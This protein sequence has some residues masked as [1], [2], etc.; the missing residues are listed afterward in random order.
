[1]FLQL[2]PASPQLYKMEALPNE[3][4]CEIIQGLEELDIHE[5]DVRYAKKF[6][7]VCDQH[8]KAIEQNGNKIEMRNGEVLTYYRCLQTEW[9]FQITI[10][11]NL[12]GDILNM[13]RI[14]L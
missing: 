4:W 6:K 8:F 13:N 12:C 9:V 3:I 11:M 7:A 14:R 1:M 5:T 10:V 2:N